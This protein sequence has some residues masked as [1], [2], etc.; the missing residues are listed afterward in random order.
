MNVLGAI[1]K[2]VSVRN[3]KTTQISDEILGKILKAAI[4]NYILEI[5]GKLK[6]D[7]VY[8]RLLEKNHKKTVLNLT[9]ICTDLIM[10]F[11]SI[12]N[13]ID[14]NNPVDLD[15]CVHTCRRILKTLADYLFP[16]NADLK[17]IT[18]EGCK[19]KLGEEQYVNRLLAFIDSKSNSKTYSK[20]VGSSL[21]DINKRMHSIYS[22]SC[23]GSHTELTS[24]EVERYV[25]YTYLFLDD[26]SNL[27]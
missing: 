26:I 5:N 1:A 22:A 7:E 3:Y 10:E 6:N 8:M 17:E 16:V 12:Y 27:I 23:K 24:F 19:L 25:L 11:N 18:L 14:S 2:R 15:N 13:N 21:E 4:Y 20:I 9:K